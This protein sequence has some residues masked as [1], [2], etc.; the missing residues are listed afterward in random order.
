MSQ[1]NDKMSL[2]DRKDN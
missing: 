2:C 1:E